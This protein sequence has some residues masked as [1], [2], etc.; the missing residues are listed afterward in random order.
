MQRKRLSYDQVYIY[1]CDLVSLIFGS[2]QLVNPCTSTA[3]SSM[4][5]FY[6]HVDFL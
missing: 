5:A 4:L 1:N 2:Y 6:L 3:L